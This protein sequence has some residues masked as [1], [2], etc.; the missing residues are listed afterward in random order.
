MPTR[1]GSDIV[2]EFVLADGTRSGPVSVRIDEIRYG[3]DEPGITD[4]HY[5]ATLP[6]AFAGTLAVGDSDCD[7]FVGNQRTP[8]IM[9]KARLVSGV[10]SFR[11]RAV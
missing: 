7:L 10:V 11:R 1:Y 3:P 5:R 9:E 4:F 8:L 2:G 6:I